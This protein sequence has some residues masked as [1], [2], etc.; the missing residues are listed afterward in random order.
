MTARHDCIHLTQSDDAY[1][2]TAS[3]ITTATTHWLCDHANGYPERYDMLPRW[4]LEDALAGG[5]SFQIEKHCTGCHA[6]ESLVRT[7]EVK[8]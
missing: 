5:P 1:R 3:G 7:R 8:P 4:L 2:I 6:Y